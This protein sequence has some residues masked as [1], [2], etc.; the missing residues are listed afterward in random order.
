[1]STLSGTFFLCLVNVSKSS[2]PTYPLSNKS[3]MSYMTSHLAFHTFMPF[4]LTFLCVLLI[5]VTCLLMWH[6]YYCVLQI[7]ISYL[8][9]C[10]LFQCDLLTLCDLCVL[11]VQQALHFLHDFDVSLSL[12]TLCVPLSNVSYFPICPTFLCGHSPMCPP[13]YIS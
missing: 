9:M 13:P 7:Y 12:S 1:M 6:I 4:C 3:Y 8:F 5:Y 2:L 10:L 11:Y